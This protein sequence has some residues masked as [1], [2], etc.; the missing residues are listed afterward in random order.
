MAVNNVIRMLN[1]TRGLNTDGDVDSDS[2]ADKF[3]SNNFFQDNKG[4]GPEIT[5][6]HPIQDVSFEDT[7]YLVG[8][9]FSEQANVILISNSG[10]ETVVGN[11]TFNT[12]S[13]VVFQMPQ[14]SE[15]KFGKPYRIRITSS[16]LGT[17]NTTTK[18]L[19]LANNSLFQGRSHGFATVAWKGVHKWG[20]S[21]GSNIFADPFE[22]EDVTGFLGSSSTGSSSGTHGYNAG[23]FSPTGRATQISKF[24]FGN[25]STTAD[26]GD[27]SVARYQAVGQSSI[28]QGYGFTSGGS[29]APASPTSNVIDKFPFASD[30]NATDVGNLTVARNNGTGHSSTTHGYTTGGSTTNIIDKFPFSTNSNATDVGDLLATK[31]KSA[32]TSSSTHGYSS[33]NSGG[34]GPGKS[35]IEK[36]SFSSDS[37]S[38]DVGD[39]SAELS[40][41][42]GVSSVDHG[43][44]CGSDTVSQSTFMN[45][46]PFASDSN[47]TEMGQTDPSSGYILNAGKTAFRDFAGW[48]TN[49]PYITTMTVKPLAGQGHQV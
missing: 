22:L 46:F 31:D 25:F 37:N 30:A 48:G 33:G 27:L 7:I 10:I 13:N 36:F 20:F 40:G 41:G 35:Q 23:G 19:N 6:V 38:T 43:Y 32:G 9:G 14:T 12:S 8:T 47:G 5:S 45:R 17:S 29:E 3:V 21:S 4:S 42:I 16:D 34:P 49:S 28:A 2:L 24:H 26:V 18:Q 11:V 39:L 15:G 1:L 44:H